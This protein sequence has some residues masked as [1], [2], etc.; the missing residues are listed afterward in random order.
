MN[1]LDL[2]TKYYGSLY[3]KKKW[4]PK[5]VHAQIIKITRFIANIIVPNYLNGKH[6]YSS[7]VS[8]KGI[9]VS[10]TSF[11]ARINKVWIVV[12]CMLR[13]SILPDKIILWLSKEQFPDEKSVPIS[14]RRR[15]NPTFEI[16]FV[17][18]D[19]RSHKKYYYV[20][21]EYPNHLVFLV[22]DDLFYPTD[23]LER[24]FKSFQSNPHTVICNYGY[25]ITYNE[26]GS[27]NPYAQWVLAH[28]GANGDSSFFGSGGGT[29]FVPSMLYKDITNIEL[30]IKLTPL[31][32]DIWLNAMVRLAG[33]NIILLNNGLILPVLSDSSALSTVNRD[34]N[35]N[36]EQI[37]NVESRYGDIFDRCV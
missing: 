3:K 13:Q 2:F 29:L 22:D 26:N 17:E 5:K 37:C 30:A 10:M 31:A 23:L 4:V 20:A 6:N 27:H 21:K 7:R 11:P 24:S 19:I 32:D 12:E 35:K 8:N 14:L 18:G 9:I 25:T 1:I 28:E 34:G 36:D 15:I 33:V 16:R